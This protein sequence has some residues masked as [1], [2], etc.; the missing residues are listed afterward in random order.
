MAA[1]RISFHVGVGTYDPHV[2]P[3]ALPLLSAAFDARSMFN[4]ALDL[5]YTPFDLKP[6]VAWDGTPPAP[7]NVFIDSAA[8]YDAVI[9]AFEQA[10]DM[11]DDGDSCLISFSSHGTQFKNNAPQPTPDGPLNEAVCLFD[12]TLLDDVIYGLL[13][14][15]KKGVDV[16]LMLDCCRAGA[17]SPDIGALL[18]APLPPSLAARQKTQLPSFLAARQTAPQFGKAKVIRPPNTSAAPQRAIDLQAKFKE[19]N[20]LALSANVA[21]FEAC[22]DKEDTFDGIDKNRASLY[23]FKFIEAVKSGAKSIG[24]LANAIAQAQPQVPKCTPRF[25][26]V[27]EDAFLKISLRPP[28]PAPVGTPPAALVC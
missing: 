8:K 18:E 23:T 15:F 19:T 12:Y 14:G 21:A 2:Y 1:K 20:R 6:A 24:E 9:D 13:G 16:I 17:T 22:G 4:T 27:G 3:T 5:G 11:L 28:Q 25:Q 10:A 7:P 26:R